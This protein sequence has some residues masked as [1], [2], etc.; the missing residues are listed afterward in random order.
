MYHPAVLAATASVPWFAAYIAENEDRDAAED[1][2]AV[3]YVCAI[4]L[5][6]SFAAIF[7]DANNLTSWFGIATAP[8][9]LNL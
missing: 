6:L 7:D 8:D 4:G 1:L 2:I 5:L 3:L 9:A